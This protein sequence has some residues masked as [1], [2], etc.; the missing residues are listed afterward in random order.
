MD[1]KTGCRKW[2][3]SLFLVLII[4]MGG[5]YF[6]VNVE[7]ETLGEEAKKA[8]PGEF[9]TLSMGE[10]HYQLSGAGDAPVVVLVHGF[11]VPS[12]V[13]NPTVSALEEAGYQVLV[14]DLYGRGYSERVAG[15]YDIDLFTHQL[16]LLLESLGIVEPV[17]V[18]GLSMGG[19][20]AARFAQLHPEQVSSVILISPEVFQPTVKDFFPLNIPYVGEYLMGAVMEPFLLPK[21]QAADFFHPE[22]YPDWED[23]YRI[24]LQYKG[25]GRALLS[26]IRSLADHDPANEYRALQETNLP[27][28][29]L[30]GE[31]DQTIG[32]DQIETLKGLLPV[33][34]IEIIPEAGHLPQYEQP[35][36]VNPAII[37][38][39]GK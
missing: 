39:M 11:S 4:G 19:P 36:I 9:I 24:Q 8:A 2:I 1:K 18:G 34:R 5:F 31:A 6:L 7:R 23:R 3:V 25:T 33:M 27:V 14:F 26:T 20:I 21:L 30:W 22:R 15:V 17:V 12:Y 38:F 37:E 32:W 16:E 28:L 10:V 35:G 29:L 13:W